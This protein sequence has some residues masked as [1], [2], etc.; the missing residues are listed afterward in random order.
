MRPPLPNVGKPQGCLPEV[1]LA[2]TAIHDE[3]LEAAGLRS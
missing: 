1:A 3:A 2:P